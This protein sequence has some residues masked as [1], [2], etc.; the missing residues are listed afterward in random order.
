MSEVRY[1]FDEN[2]G[3]R[4]RKALLQ[5]APE[6]TIW[7]VGDAGAP[8]LGT[9]DPEILVWCETHNFVL[10]TNNRCSMP[11]HLDDHLRIGRHI[12][13]IFVLRR[14]MRIPDTIAELILIWEASLPNEFQDQIRYLPISTPKL[15]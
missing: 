2:L 3:S 14:E 11:L 4:L 1:L 7:C 15:T 12:P 9:Q 10:V 6:I 5:A 13:G 8:P